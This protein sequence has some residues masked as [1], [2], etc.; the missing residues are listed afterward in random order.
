MKEY[1]KQIYNEGLATTFYIKPVNYLKK[2]IKNKKI[3]DV[4]IVIFKIIYSIIV[5]IFAI[6]I[7]Y[8]KLK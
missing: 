1:I 8:Y 7:L 2:V 3:L 6:M 5:F 4:M